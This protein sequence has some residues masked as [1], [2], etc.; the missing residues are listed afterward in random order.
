MD[1][2]S[3]DFDSLPCL[4][5]SDEDDSEPLKAA[6]SLFQEGGL[7][8]TAASAAHVKRRPFGMT[9][10]RVRWPPSLGERLVFGCTSWHH[11]CFCITAA[12]L[13]F[14]EHGFI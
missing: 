9:L 5:D 11:L 4:D 2:S 1:H 10:V 14:D 8:L 3:F 6:A 7:W 12:I 13:H